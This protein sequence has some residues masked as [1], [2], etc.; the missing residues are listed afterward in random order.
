MSETRTMLL[1][2]DE[3][4]NIVAAAHKGEGSVP[5]L[6]V[7]ISPRPG[8]TVHEVEVPEPVTRLTGRDFHLFMSQARFETRA[9]KLS[10]PELRVRHQHDED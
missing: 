3:R 8:Q 5:G 6:A 7:S 4:G 10:F 2:T 1:I 9:V